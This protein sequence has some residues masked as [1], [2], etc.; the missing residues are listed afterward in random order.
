MKY[1]LMIYTNPAARAAIEADSDQVMAE[2]DGLLKEM[3]ETGEWVSGMALADTFRTVRV[4]DGVP[5]VT[6]GPFMEAKE[7]LAGVCLIECDS[8]ERATELAAR[9]PDARY[10]AMEVRPLLDEA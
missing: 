3:Q 5:A 7:V 1:L 8:I 10:C 9:W 4:R 2:V 6:D